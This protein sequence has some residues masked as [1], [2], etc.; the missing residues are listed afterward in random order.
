MTLLPSTW[1]TALKSLPCLGVGRRMDV[2]WLSSL[3]NVPMTLSERVLLNQ[4]YTIIPIPQNF[5]LNG[6]QRVGKFLMA[7][8]ILVT[9]NC[10]NSVLFQPWRTLSYPSN[11]CCSLSQVH[12]PQRGRASMLQPSHSTMLAIN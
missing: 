4:Q 11:C 6:M 5:L 2:G 8:G 7:E 12:L 10:Q 9:P 1:L 3:G